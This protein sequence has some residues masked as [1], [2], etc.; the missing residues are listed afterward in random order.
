MDRLNELQ[1]A[2]RELSDPLVVMRRIVDQTMRLIPAADGAVVELVREGQ[3]VYV[4]GAGS[5]TAH[6]GLTLGLGDSLSGLA[7]RSGRTLRCQDAD[8]DPRVDAAACR[9]VGAA[10]MVCV[11]LHHRSTSVG[12]LKVVSSRPHAFTDADARRLGSLAEFISAAI[13]AASDISQIAE[14]MAALRPGASRPPGGEAGEEGYASGEGGAGREPGATGGEPGPAR[15]KPGAAGGEPG[16]AR[17]YPG[18]AGGERGARAEP[19]AAGGEPGA[20]GVKLDAATHSESLSVGEFMANVLHPGVVDSLASRRRI[21]RLLSAGRLAMHVQP[22][23]CLG[24]GQ[25]VGVE[26]LARFP[27]PPLQPPEVW[28]AEAQAAGFGVQLQL[29]AAASALELAAHLPEEVFLAFNIGPDALSAPEARELLSGVSGERLVIELTEHLRSE[30]YP[31]LR[32]ALQALRQRGLRLAIDDTGAGF[33]SLAT[34]VNLAPDL[35]KLDRQ[36]TRGIDLD[37]VRRALAQALVS[38]AADT[39]AEVIAEGIENEGEL[40]TVAEL[41]IRY[42]QGQLIAPPG[43]LERLPVSFPHVPRRLAV[44]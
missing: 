8:S 11:P 16:G 33:A 25:L 12:V 24:T 18:E 32:R 29:L 30:D 41:G 7:V 19:G 1:G 35:I 4:C 27:A 23:V 31:Q 17:A 10:A 40:E 39:G 28:F 20:T 26:A 34:V 21:T 2:I 14:R 5:L 42:G 3:L 43:P 37:P 22:V 13:A 44:D 38:F 15:A 36:F 6:S 9:R